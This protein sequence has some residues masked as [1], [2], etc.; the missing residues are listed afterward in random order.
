MLDMFINAKLCLMLV[1]LSYCSWYSSK[2]VNHVD[3]YVYLISPQTNPLADSASLYSFTL[4][5]KIQSNL[6]LELSFYQ[7]I[8]F[9]WYLNQER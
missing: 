3:V 8:A 5:V 1:G 6:V 9:F 2:E 7:F 4:R